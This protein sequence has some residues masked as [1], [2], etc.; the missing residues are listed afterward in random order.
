MKQTEKAKHFAE[1]HVQG[2]PLVPTMRGMRGVQN[3]YSTPARKRSRR[4][5]GPSRRR[6]VI[7]TARLSRSSSLS[8]SSQGSRRRS[9]SLSP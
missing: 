6:R 4:A 3:S 7:V 1:L 5:V 9:M 2:A 8:R